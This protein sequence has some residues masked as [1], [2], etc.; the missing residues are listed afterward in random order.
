MSCLPVIAER[1]R[2]D[3]PITVAEFM[4][5]ALYHPSE[6]YYAT[7]ARRSGRA[8]DFFTSVDV[9]PEFGALLGRQFAE[10]WRSLDPRP[11]RFDVVEAGAGDGR[12]T[13]DI[14]AWAG[15][16]DADFLAAARF[17][18][19]ELSAEARDAQR[20]T[21]GTS[22]D[23][24]VTSGDTLPGRVTGVIFANELLDAMPV[25][26][27]EMSADGLREVFVAVEGDRLVERIGLPSDPALARYLEAAGTDLEP[28]WRA[29]VGLDAIAWVGLAAASLDRGFLLLIDYGHLAAELHSDLHTGGT[30][31]AFSRHVVVGGNGPPGRP[32]WLEAPGERDLTVH[33]D[34]TSI[35]AEAER[36]GCVTLGMLDQGYFL[37]GLGLA[38][39]LAAPA[40]RPGDDRRR[41]MALKSLV[42]PGGPGSTHKVMVF[43]K[44]CGRP[45]LAALSGAGRL[46]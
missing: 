29:E 14:V 2:R 28:G 32:P 37:L 17:H 20:A 41:R 24:V 45:T 30:L 13:R 4:E 10:M 33:V 16:E 43:A 11:G 44:G 1:I 25:H 21:L 42:L 26:L 39:R 12:L 22:A 46:T 35:R 27:V 40:D 38:D 31:R 15:A 6:G 23:R 8:G 36:A 7:A 5:L 34:L 9:G 3:G 19:V 18:L